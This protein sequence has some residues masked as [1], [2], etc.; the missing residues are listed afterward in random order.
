MD[1]YPNPN[2]GKF[3]ISYSLP[4]STIVEFYITDLLGEKVF[5][6][7][8]NAF[9]PEGNFSFQADE[10]NLNPGSYLVV[11]KTKE[12]TISKGIVVLN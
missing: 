4:T 11:M 9:Y 6:I 10:I 7:S 8:S 1:L 12:R 5:T 3:V 2:T